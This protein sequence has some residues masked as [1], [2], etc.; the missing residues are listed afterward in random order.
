MFLRKVCFVDKNKS[1]LGLIPLKSETLKWTEDE[2]GLVV[3]EIKNEGWLN[4]IFQVLFRK[5]EYSYIHLD[6]FG[7]YTWKQIDGIRTVLAI[8]LAIERRFGSEVLPL[9]ERLTHFFSILESYGFITIKN[10]EKQ[11]KEKLV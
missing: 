3:F 1:Y 8:G 10:N 2:K 9:Y 6:E 7:S 5:P 4:R 11:N